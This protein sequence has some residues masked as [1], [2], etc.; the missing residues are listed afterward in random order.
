MAFPTVTT[1]L[2]NFNRAN[3][4]GGDWTADVAGFGGTEMSI[5]SDTILDPCS[6]SNYGD[7]YWDITTFGPDTE[8]YITLVSELLGTNGTLQ[9]FARMVTPG[10]AAADGY[11]LT[12]TKTA[13]SATWQLYEI[14]NGAETPIGSSATQAIA[15]TEKVGLEIISDAIKGY[16]Y[17]GG[18]WNSTP[19]VS[20]TDATYG[21]ENYCGVGS[22]NGGSGRPKYDDFVAG[23]VVA[24]GGRTTKNTRAFPLGV[25][26]GMNWRG[27]L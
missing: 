4:I 23:T 19:I 1:V 21:S 5:A 22:Y 26:V 2:D 16:H 8:V 25:E 6:N 10:S 12:V 14:L 24:G 9:L 13:G 20:T 15:L 7:G 11:E 3:P 18:A 27:A 17:T